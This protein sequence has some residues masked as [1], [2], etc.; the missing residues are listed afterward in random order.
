VNADMP[1]WGGKRALADDIAGR[2]QRKVIV[3]G[4]AQAIRA[5][6]LTASR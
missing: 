1:A 3:A 6:L 2:T 5:E 4:L